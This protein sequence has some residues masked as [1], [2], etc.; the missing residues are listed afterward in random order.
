MKIKILS[1]LL[2]L[3]TSNIAL[4]GEWAGI[5]EIKTMFIYPT[6]AVI[7]QGGPGPGAAGCAPDDTWSFEWSQFDQPTQNRIQSMLLTAYIS[8]TPIQV[9][10][11][12]S[13]CGPENKKKFNGYLMF[14]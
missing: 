7:K 4:A 11:E 3:L 2:F 8:K 10:V 14:P 13:G 6:Y 1:I 9:M 5:G 12:T